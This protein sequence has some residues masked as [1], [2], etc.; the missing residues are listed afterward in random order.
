MCSG[1]SRSLLGNLY[2][3]SYYTRLISLNALTLNNEQIVSDVS[4]LHKC[5]YGK[6]DY[7][8]E[9]IGMKLAAKNE[10]GGK[11]RLTQHH[12]ASCVSKALFSILQS[13]SG[14]LSLKEYQKPHH[15]TNLKLHR[16]HLQKTKI[17]AWIVLLY[18]TGGGG[19]GVGPKGQF[20][21][22]SL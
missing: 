14:T 16:V 15:L 11:F 6:V 12:R 21:G 13:V 19:G 2:D 5:M 3:T 9:D 10:R 7:C 8:L 1:A 22:A 4:L 17:S 18:R 20:E